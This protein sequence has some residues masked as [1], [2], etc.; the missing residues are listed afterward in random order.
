MAG[1]KTDEEYIKEQKELK[2][3][4][5]K[6]EENEPESIHDKDMSVLNYIIETDFR[7]HYESLD[8]EDKRAFWRYIIKEIHVEGNEIVSVDFNS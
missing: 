3:A 7:T 5:K 6:A 1:N 2:D 8:D 4:I